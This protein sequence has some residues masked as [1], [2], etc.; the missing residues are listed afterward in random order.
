MGRLTDKW[1]AVLE[2]SDSL[3]LGKTPKPGLHKTSG[4]EYSETKRYAKK[5]ALRFMKWFSSKWGYFGFWVSPYFW[6]L[7]KANFYLRGFRRGCSIL[8]SKNIV[9]F[10]HDE[11]MVVVMKVRFSGIRSKLGPKC[12]WSSLFSWLLR[13][14]WTMNQLHLQLR[15]IIRGNR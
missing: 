8:V 13:A 7:E 3:A 14:W 11:K 1:F 2:F 6:S 12:L 10:Y 5:S 15:L 9:R 4:E